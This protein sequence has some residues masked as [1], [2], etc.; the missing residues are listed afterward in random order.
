MLLQ[1]M[2]SML[3]TL[4]QLQFFAYLYL[5]VMVYAWLRNNIDRARATNATFYAAAVLTLLELARRNRMATAG[6]PVANVEFTA[7]SALTLL[8]VVLAFWSVLLIEA[9]AA[10]QYGWMYSKLSHAIRSTADWLEVH[11]NPPDMLRSLSDTF[12]EHAK[13]AH[14]VHEVSKALHTSSGSNVKH[15]AQRMQEIIE[16]KS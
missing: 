4:G 10:K 6:D 13:K 16:E 9:L 5:G 7:L 2:L 8:S 3:G 12:D 15:D 11:A 1:T 14:P